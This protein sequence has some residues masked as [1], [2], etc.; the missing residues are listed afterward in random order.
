MFMIEEVLSVK[1]QG[2]GRASQA[3]SPLQPAASGLHGPVVQTNPIWGS[4]GW[5]PQGNSAKQSQFRQSA[6]RVEGEM[7][8]TKPNLGK[9]AYLGGRADRC[10][11]D[12]ACCTDKPNWPEPFAPNEAN[13]NDAGIRLLYEQT[14]FS[15][16]GHLGAAPFVP[17]EP[18]FGGEA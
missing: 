4:P 11:P 17:N 12:E 1:C 9:L 8:Q 14:Q 6:G 16:V 18:N 3:G 10:L 7:R 13:F 2:L 5:C 15:A